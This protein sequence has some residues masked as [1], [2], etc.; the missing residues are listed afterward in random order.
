MIT[1][2]QTLKFTRVYLRKYGLF[3]VPLKKD[4][5]YTDPYHDWINERSLR[6]FQRFTIRYLG[7]QKHPD[8]VGKLI[9]GTTFAIETKGDVSLERGL[10]QADFYRFGFHYSFLAIPGNRLNEFI[11][12]YAKNH[13]IG[14]LTI[15][16]SGKVCEK[17]SP[18]Q[19]KPNVNVSESIF[20]QF[21]GQLAVERWRPNMYNLPMHYL[22]VPLLIEKN[23][24]DLSE[25]SRRF[26]EEYYPTPK[27]VGNLIPTLERWELV[28]KDGTKISLTDTGETIKLLLSSPSNLA[29]AVEKRKNR[30]EKTPLI[31]SSPTDAMVLRLILL[32]DPIVKLIIKTLRK[33]FVGQPIAM[34]ELFKKAYEMDPTLAKMAFLVSEKL[35]EI[36]EITSKSIKRFKP[37]YYKSGFFY[38]F[39]SFLVHAGILMDLGLGTPS[40]R[41]YVP[42][43]DFYQL[44]I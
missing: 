31:E 30:R 7:V 29:S 8:L 41:D 16:E 17:I 28:K 9:N 22:V 35:D 19:P 27:D 26:H 14:I 44:A 10:I 20:R 37:T 13:G 21:S 43:K 3:G 15:Y 5:L 18:A 11:I 39:K 4:N 40:N 33:N 36:P 42:E 1:E 25:L 6:P 2:I 24:I 32:N 12:S 34:P 38:Q 23:K